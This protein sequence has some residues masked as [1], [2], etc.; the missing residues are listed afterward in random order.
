[1]KMKRPKIAQNCSKG[2]TKRYEMVSMTQN[3]TERHRIAQKVKKMFKNGLKEAQNG[4][5]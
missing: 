4:T 5:E 3:S 1:M 2:E